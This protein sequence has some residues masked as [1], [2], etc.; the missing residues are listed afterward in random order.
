MFFKLD[1]SKLDKVKLK[2]LFNHSFHELGDTSYYFHLS[3]NIAD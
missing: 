1:Q 2:S 3:R